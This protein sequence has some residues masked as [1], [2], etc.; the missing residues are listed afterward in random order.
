VRRTTLVMVTASSLWTWRQT[1]LNKACLILTLILV[2]SLAGSMA[3][4]TSSRTSE[5]TGE[6]VDDSVISNK[7]RAQLLGDKELNITQIDVKTYKGV[8]QLSG[9]V[10]TPAAKNRAGTVAASV[11]G[12]E[13]VRN[14]LIVK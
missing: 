4:C 7:V 9:F 5:S 14:N 1:V 6:Y 11:S 10:D 13:Q 3:A 12:V 8:V 2:G